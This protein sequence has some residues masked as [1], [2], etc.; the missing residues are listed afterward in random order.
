MRAR[1]RVCVLAGGGV[2]ALFC[3]MS[4]SLELV[5]TLKSEFIEAVLLT[6]SGVRGGLS[7]CRSDARR[8]MARSPR[9]AARAK[10]TCGAARARPWTATDLCSRQPMR[11]R[12]NS[13]QVARSEIST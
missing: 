1:A 7:G 10:I 4:L 5:E 13:K 11:G 3:I 2:G 8:V 6:H 12:R 9:T